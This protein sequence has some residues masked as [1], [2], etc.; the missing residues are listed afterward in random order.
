MNGPTSSTILIKTVTSFGGEPNVQFSTVEIQAMAILFKLILVGKF[1]YNEP[2]VKLIRKFFISFRLKGTS[3]VSL[4]NNRHVLIQLDVEEDYSCLWVRQ[5]QYINE[6]AMRIFKWTIDF[7][8]SE[9]SYIVQVWISFPCLPVHF[10][11]CKEALFSITSAI[12]KPLRIDQATASFARP[13]VAR[14]LVEYDITQPPL[15]QIRIGMRDF[16]F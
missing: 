14:V 16:G 11:H 4:L 9:E 7:W 5:T 8:C 6:S 15:P 3:K 13:S 2:S 12:G 1:S 10:M